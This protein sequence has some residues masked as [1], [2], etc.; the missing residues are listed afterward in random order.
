[1]L[2]TQS[3]QK[4]ESS[5]ILWNQ[6]QKTEVKIKR[7]NKEVKGKYYFWSNTTTQRLCVSMSRRDYFKIH[8]HV[9]QLQNTRN[10]SNQSYANIL[11]RA[12]LTLLRIA[13]EG[14]K[15]H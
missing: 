7:C 12:K 2:N 13:C 1:M 5:K 4:R 8:G 11:G 14:V 15:F 9:L 10:K 6:L 3:I